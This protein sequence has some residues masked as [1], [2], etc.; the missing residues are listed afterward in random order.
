MTFDFNQSPKDVSRISIAEVTALMAK[1][2]VILV[3]VRDKASFATGHMPGAMSG[4]RFQV[5]DTRSD[6][7]GCFAACQQL[8][9]SLA[10]LRCDLVLDDYLRGRRIPLC[11]S[12]NS[13]D[14]SIDPARPLSIRPI[15]LSAL[16]G[17]S[18]SRAET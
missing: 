6:R 3:D 11:A 7:D 9:V 17:R 12:W 1:K 18:R 5:P 15:S 13:R 4:V 10:V 2:Q 16:K 14:S 8:G